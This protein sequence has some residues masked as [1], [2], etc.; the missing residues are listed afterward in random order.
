MLANRRLSRVRRAL[1]AGART[2]DTSRGSGGAQRGTDMPSSGILD[3]AI[4]LAFVFGA[5]AA[6]S[7]VGTELIARGLRELLDGED[8]S[9]NLATARVQYDAVKDLITGD[10]AAAEAEATGA[11]AAAATGAAAA[12]PERRKAAP[13]ARPAQRAPG[14]SSQRSGQRHLAEG[15]AG[16]ERSATATLLGGPILRSQGMVGDISSRK[17]QMRPAKK[18]PRGRAAS[19]AGGPAGPADTA[20]S[21]AGRAH[22]ASGPAGPADTASSLGEPAD[23]A[24]G[25]PEPAHAASGPAAPAHAASGPAAPAGAGS[26]WRQLASMPGRWRN[27][28]QLP[29]YLSARSFAE[30][31]VDLVAPDSAGVT[32]MGM[33]QRSVD[34]LP[35]SMSVFK[36]SLQALVKNANGDIR[37]FRASVEH[38]YD[39]HMDRVSGWYKRRVAKITLL[40]GAI[41]VLLLNVNAL[42][43]GRTLY[44]DSAVRAAVSNVA[45]RSTSCPAPAGTAAA[46]TAAAGHAQETCLADIQAR[47]SAAAQAGLPIG[48]GTVRDCV[49]PDAQCNWLDQRGILSRHGSSGWQL[50]LVLIGFLITITSLVPGARFWFGLLAKLGSM[51][52]TG[53]KPAAPAS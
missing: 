1:T 52:S 15:T 6:L 48:W 44:A 38:W 23:A 18:R 21:L 26:R 34:A 10:G 49:L 3:L 45:A 24:S 5:T 2:I 46:G 30:A 11:K 42:T 47:L 4:G 7:S 53:P 20:S 8:A 28:R 13:A 51:R 43:I 33:V 25:P 39:D 50:A 22:A 36:P 19:Q 35:D 37:R 41:L 9:M 32:T 29:S 17:L 27:Q 16:P 40:V 12:R 14:E 31:V